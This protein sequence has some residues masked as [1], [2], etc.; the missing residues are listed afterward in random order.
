MKKS[1]LLLLAAGSLAATGYAQDIKEKE[2]A[3]V[4]ATLAADD[5]QGRYPGTPGIEKAAQFISSEFEKA[6]IQPLPGEKSFLQEFGKFSLKTS[7]VS[8]TV[9]G[10]LKDWP[11]VA[12]GTGR[13]FDWEKDSSYNVAYANEPAELMKILR[14]PAAV[15]KNTLVYG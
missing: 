8:L 6:G 10:E 1:L 3:R 2:V 13:S 9:S 4:I 5:M 7:S 12:V 15:Q 11:V 14:D